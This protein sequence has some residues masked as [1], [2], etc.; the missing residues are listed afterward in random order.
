MRIS[1][2]AGHFLEVGDA[3]FH[4]GWVLNRR[5]TEP[6]GSGFTMNM[7]SGAGLACLGRLRL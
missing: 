4:G 2:G 1:A 3:F 6:P 7:F 5:W